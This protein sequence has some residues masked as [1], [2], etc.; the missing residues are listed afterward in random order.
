VELYFS[1]LSVIYYIFNKKT[2]VLV[3]K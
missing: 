1:K 3:I 2:A